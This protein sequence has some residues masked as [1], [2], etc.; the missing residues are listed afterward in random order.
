MLK[1]VPYSKKYN[2]EVKKLLILLQNYHV[3]ID[4]LNI[5]KDC[6]KEIDYYFKVIYKRIKK[7]HGIIF[8]AIDNGEVIGLIIG[9]MHKQE[10]EGVTLNPVKRGEINKLIVKPEFRNNKIGEELISTMEEWF[11]KKKCQYIDIDVFAANESG[12]NFYKKHNYD[13]RTYKII[14]KIEYK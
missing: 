8:L 9:V 10:F 3:K 2:E 12:L 6:S 13:I 5:M 11:K 1:I 7:C 14:K 4:S